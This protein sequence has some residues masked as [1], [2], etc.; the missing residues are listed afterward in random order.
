MPSFVKYASLGNAG[1]NFITISEGHF[2][3]LPDIELDQAG[4]PGASRHIHDK[5]NE[6]Y[7]QQVDGEWVAQDADH[8]GHDGRDNTP[9]Q[10][11]RGKP[12]HNID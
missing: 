12:T 1:W 4:Y 7:A 3:G 10:D 11:S 8:P 9:V 2:S 6:V 5:E